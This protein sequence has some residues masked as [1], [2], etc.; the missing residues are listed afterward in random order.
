MANILA[1]LGPHSSKHPCIYC[2]GTRGVWEP[3]ATSRTLDNIMENFY[4]WQ[5]ESGKKSQFKYFYNCTNSPL[6]ADNTDVEGSNLL[7]LV[8]PP[9]ALH[10]NLGIVNTL[11][12]DMLTQYPPLEKWLHEELNIIQEEYHGKNF[13]GKNFLFNLFYQNTYM[14]LMLVQYDFSIVVCVS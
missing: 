13:E 14:E 9:P 12:T 1:G 4:T 2:D 8:C 6:I 5:R 10:L 11:I 3:D 7:L